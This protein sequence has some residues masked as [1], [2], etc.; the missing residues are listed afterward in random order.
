MSPSA[1]RRRAR[2]AH[3]PQVSALTFRRIA[4]VSVACYALL[5]VTGGAVRLTGSGLGC[6]DWPTCSHASITPS[7][8]FH[9]LVEFSNRMVSVAVTIVSI[10][11]FGAALR[12]TPRRRDLVGL[13]SGLI[14][15]L[16]AQIVLGGI[17]VLTKLNPYFVALHFILTLAVLADAI[18]LLHRATHDDTSAEPVVG[19][20]LIWLARILLGTVTVLVCVGTI[21]TG[22]GP[23]AGG[24]GAKRVP[25]AFQEIAE[26]HSDIALFLIGATLAT[27]FALHHAKAPAAVQ[28]RARTVLEVLALQ[29]AL[30]YTQYFLHDNAF[31]VELHLAGATSVWCAILAF[32]LGLHRH[33]AAVVAAPAVT[34]AAD[35]AAIGAAAHSG[36]ASAP[37]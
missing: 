35:E 11:A 32:Y 23:H 33:P 8:S 12:R 25:I 21:V 4:I 19:T 3:L 15:G 10:V 9:P 6:L 29:G 31:V 26:F 34:A 30:G 28:R 2:S 20:D 36:V 5:V 24:P 16:L 18:V 27:L 22:A 1:F 14:V 7:V 17:V 13:A 37:A